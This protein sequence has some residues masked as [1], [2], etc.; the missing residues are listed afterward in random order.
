MLIEMLAEE[1]VAEKMD[2]LNRSSSIYLFLQQNFV[3]QILFV[4]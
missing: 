1:L 2:K 3:N 4:D